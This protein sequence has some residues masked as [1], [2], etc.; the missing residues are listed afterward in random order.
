[1]GGRLGPRACGRF[2][3]A[4]PA[5][6]QRRGSNPDDASL[7]RL[8]NADEDDAVQEYR[9]EIRGTPRGGTPLRLP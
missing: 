6:S 9:V 7:G 1:M 8:G 2:P 3:V 4:A 5:E